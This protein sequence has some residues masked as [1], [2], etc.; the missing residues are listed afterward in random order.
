MQ[1]SDILWGGEV[2]QTRALVTWGTQQCIKLR[3]CFWCVGKPFKWI[4]HQGRL[5]VVCSSAERKK[6]SSSWQLI[7]SCQ[8]CGSSKW[9]SGV[10]ARPCGAVTSL[11]FT[12]IKIES[13]RLPYEN[14]A[15]AKPACTLVLLSDRVEMKEPDL[16][17]GIKRDDRNVFS[18]WSK[19]TGSICS[20][21]VYD[22]LSSCLANFSPSC[23]HRGKAN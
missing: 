18:T 23:G 8:A 4:S 5:C 2:Q 1:C 21:L 16:A 6:N 20:W 17:A 19:T 12:T 7:E 10:S 11:T 15:R 13:A 22:S 14:E 3:F 9:F